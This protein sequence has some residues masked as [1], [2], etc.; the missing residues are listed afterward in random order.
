MQLPVNYNLISWQDKK[1]ARE[2]YVVEQDGLCHYCKSKLSGKPES[3][4]SQKPVNRS[5]FPDSFFKWP[6]HLHHCHTNWRLIQK[7][8]NLVFP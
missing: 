1:K 8:W 4:V 6:V 7:L 5:L 2:Q 3:S